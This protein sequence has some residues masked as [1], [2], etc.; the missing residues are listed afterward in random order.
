MS[1]TPR[2]SGAVRSGHT[3]AVARMRSASAERASK[4]SNQMRPLRYSINITLDGCCHHEA[5]IP[6]DEESM[7]HW[8]AEM[9][10]ADALLFGRV[11]YEMESAWRKP[12]TGAWPDWMTERDVP[13]AEAIDRAKKYVVSST[14]NKVDWNAELVQ[15]DLEQAVRRLKQQPGKGLWVGGVRLPRALGSRGPGID[16]RVRV[17]HPAGYCRARTNPA[18]RPA[19]TRPTGTR[20]SQ[21][22]PLGSR[23]D[24]ISAHTSFSVTRRACRRSSASRHG[25]SVPRRPTIRP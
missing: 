7:H 14:L 3:G 11:T 25:A 16:R 8:T 21:G 22:V 18:R 6:P 10:R 1:I 20:L 15:D 23:R 4:E 17:P 13:F 5:G 9:E 19:R 24:A 12:T 2:Q